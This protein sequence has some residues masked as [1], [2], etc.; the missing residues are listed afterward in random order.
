[1][2]MPNAMR[3]SVS[4]LNAMAAIA[5]GNQASDRRIDGSATASQN[6]QGAHASACC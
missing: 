4:E 5:T 1:M 6:R 3:E 2:N